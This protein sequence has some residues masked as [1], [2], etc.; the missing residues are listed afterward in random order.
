VGFFRLF[1]FVA[2][3]AFAITQYR[4]MR[5][6]ARADGVVDRPRLPRKLAAQRTEVKWQSAFLDPATDSEVTNLLYA[7][8]PGAADV[9]NEIVSPRTAMVDG[10][11]VTVFDH[12]R[13]WYAN[14]ERH[15]RALSCA[16]ADLGASCPHVAVQANPIEGDTPFADLHAYAAESAEL[17]R[18]FKVLTADDELASMLLEQP[19]VDYL[20]SEPR[21][22]LFAVR[23][24][25]AV[26]AF[27]ALSPMVGIPGTAS[28]TERSDDLARFAA[29]LQSRIP[30]VVRVRYPR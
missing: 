24:N 6:R 20:L 1:L 16:R 27:D 12:H 9:N 15:A 29:G 19:L 3:L 7:E 2:L 28:A 14:G 30:S 11:V 22:R 10:S 18:S 5:R 17:A 26:V 23:G 4:S 25:L 21:L 13:Q 8:L